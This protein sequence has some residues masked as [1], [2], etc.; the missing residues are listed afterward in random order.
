MATNSVY[1]KNSP[2]QSLYQKEKE[3]AAQTGAYYDSINKSFYSKAEKEATAKANN[4]ETEAE[5]E[6]E[7]VYTE[8]FKNVND[9]NKNAPQYTYKPVYGGFGGGIGGIGGQAN[10]QA[11][12]AYNQAMNYTNQLLSQLNTGKTSYT[13]QINSLMDSINNRASFAYDPDTDPLFQQYLASSMESGKTAMQDSMAQASALTG[14]YGSTYAQGVGNAAYNNFVQDAYNN[15]PEYYQ[16]ALD[17]YNS[18]TNNL[19]NK[20]NMY[21]VADAT[22]YGRLADA[23]QNNYAMA[24]DM[25][26]KEYSNY[27]D[28]LNY[29]TSLDQYN[30][31]LAYKY[32]NLAQDNAQFNAKMAYQ[33]QQ[34]QIAQQNYENELLYKAQQDAIAQN[35]EP[36]YTAPTTTQ[37]NN[38][39]K[40]YEQAEGGGFDGLKKY[41]ASLPE[42]IDVEAIM[43]Y[44]LEYGN[45]GANVTDEQNM[46]KYRIK[47]RVANGK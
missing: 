42:D 3:R 44:V 25:Y 41:I 6:Q 39:I 23:Y 32:A 38:A 19:Y 46:E 24:N 29:N 11:S 10:F 4:H 47:A 36:T 28:T 37:Y 18:E 43:D 1:T 35:A 12:D 26:G 15:L 17:A 14:G 13:D 45:R 16:T 21:N 5:R 2:Y 33:A 7:R 8:G 27:W 9:T 31:D 20:L 30:A 40:A 22:E 34:D